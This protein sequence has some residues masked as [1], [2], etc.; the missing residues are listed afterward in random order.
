MAT[1]LAEMKE[2]TAAE[3]FEALQGAIRNAY[4]KSE[5][6]TSKGTKYDACLYGV[7]DRTD[8]Q[9]AK[10]ET[11]LSKEEYRKREHQ[12]QAMR[13]AKLDE[14]LAAVDRVAELYDAY[15][16]ACEHEGIKA[17]RP[18]VPTCDCG[19]CTGMRP[20]DGLYKA[21][22]NLR[23]AMAMLFVDEDGKPEA[24]TQERAE[25]YNQALRRYH[26]L[27]HFFGQEFQ[28][29]SIIWEPITG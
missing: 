13:Q 8:D 3:L 21:E 23:V 14:W 27:A 4:A 29:L 20:I 16:A 12:F 9:I 28:P 25:R 18:A 19:R 24:I 1:K 7:Y 11:K 15:R 6:K 22:Q 10:L 26:R 17:E 2:P 5:R